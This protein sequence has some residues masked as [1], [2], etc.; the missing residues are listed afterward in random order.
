MYQ[1]KVTD[2]TCG[3]CAASVRNA[4]LRV[5]GVRSIQADPASKDVLVDASA[6]VTREA[7]VAAINEAGYTEIT[8]LAESGA[9]AAS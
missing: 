7:I 1:F 3:G 6:D 5:P 8:A 4:V 9:T 2:M